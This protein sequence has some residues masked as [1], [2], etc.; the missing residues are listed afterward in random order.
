M[1]LGSGEV[2]HKRRARIEP[3]ERAQRGLESGTKERQ[4]MSLRDDEIRRDERNTPGYRLA[5]QTIR[6]CMILIALAAERDPRSAIDE[7]SSGNGRAR[8]TGPATRQRR[9]R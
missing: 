7:E 9:S 8:D 2:N 6:F 3:L 5:E 4:T 1:V